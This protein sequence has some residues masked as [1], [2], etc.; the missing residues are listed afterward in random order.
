MAVWTLS[1]FQLGYAPRSIKKL[2]KC[3]RFFQLSILLFELTILLEG[4]TIEI[5]LFRMNHNDFR[6][7]R[8]CL[9]H[10][11]QFF[12]NYREIRVYKNSVY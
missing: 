11:M 10:A 3:H 7:Y 4:I 12:F 9:R 8:S 6:Y 1:I 2:Y 5:Y